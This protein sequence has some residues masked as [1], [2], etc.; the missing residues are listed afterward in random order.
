M[1]PNVGATGHT[2]RK[3]KPTMST[4]LGEAL[5]RERRSRGMTQ[6]DMSN[7][8]EITQPAYHRW[9]S[10]KANPSDAYW[11]ELADFLGLDMDSFVALMRDVEPPTTQRELVD[12]VARLERALQDLHQQFR[13]LRKENSRAET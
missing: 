4:P 10:G 11:T 8:L 7:R 13:E 5:R 3:G 12:R 1:P 2:T 6:A 9:E